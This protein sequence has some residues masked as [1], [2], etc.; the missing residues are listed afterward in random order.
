MLLLFDLSCLE[1]AG[2]IHVVN[3]FVL[4]RDILLCGFRKLIVQCIVYFKGTS[5]HISTQ[6]FREKN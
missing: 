5:E 4:V 3:K 2:D 6:Y 1:K